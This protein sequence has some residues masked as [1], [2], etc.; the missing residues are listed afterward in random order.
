M[1]SNVY[2]C[3]EFFRG[4]PPA[5]LHQKN[6]QL[7]HQLANTEWLLCVSL[8]A[9]QRGGLYQKLEEK[10]ADI[11][12]YAVRKLKLYPQKIS[13]LLSTA[14]ALE[15]LPHLSQAFREGKLCWGKVREIKRVATPETE[16]TWVNFALDH[17]VVAV[18]RR[19]AVSPREWKHGKAL[20]ASVHGRPEV[21]VAEVT[22]MLTLPLD[23]APPEGI[24]ENTPSGSDADESTEVDTTPESPKTPIPAP[25]F[26]RVVHYLS[27]DEYAV[28]EQAAQRV[29]ARANK[30][31]NRSAIL[32][33]WCNSELSG[34]TAA[35][36]ARHHVLVRI[37][38]RG[39]AWYET[40]RGILPA[41]EAVVEAARATGRVIELPSEFQPPPE[42][43]ME[44][45]R[46]KSSGRRKDPSNEVLRYIF[47]RA[48]NRCQRCGSRLGRLHIHHHVPVSEGGDNSPERL[49]VLCLACHTLKHREDFEKRRDWAAARQAALDRKARQT[50]T[51]QDHFGH[52]DTS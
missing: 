1:L 8:L 12:D 48:G 18:Q 45:S 31:M 20:A 22:Q 23:E 44:F 9:S 43:A 51:K 29:R 39:Q 2:E 34:G 3:L 37:N 21:T 16:E 41:D 40:D 14:R 11:Y 42:I 36:R 47:A 6:L 15:K 38:D 52:P 33:E 10:F 4:L 49:E 35:A 32:M 50:E 5:K 24:S 28:Y 19:V 26:I 17:D 30:P 27:P 13:E 7:R 46:G 25:K